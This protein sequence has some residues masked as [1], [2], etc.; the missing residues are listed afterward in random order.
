MSVSSPHHC[1]LDGDR[2]AAGDRRRTCLQAAAQRRM[3]AGRLSCFARNGRSPGE[4]SRSAPLR[5]RRS[6][7]SRRAARSAH[8]RGR[9]ERSIRQRGSRRTWRLHRAT[10][11]VGGVGARRSSRVEATGRI[12]AP[13]K[14]G[15]AFDQPDAFEGMEICHAAKTA[16]QCGPRPWVQRDPALFHPRIA[17]RRGGAHRRRDL[18][19]PRPLKRPQARATPWPVPPGGASVASRAKAVMPTTTAPTSEKTTCQVSEGIVCFTMPCVA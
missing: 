18:V 2:Q 6:R 9:M 13:D 19:T 16:F 1:G 4:E 10:E 8:Q 15:Q 5:H 12:D 7:R 3:A 17:N 11:G 14:Q